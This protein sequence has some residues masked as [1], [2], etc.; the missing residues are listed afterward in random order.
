MTK[1]YKFIDLFSGCG[2]FSCGLEMAGFE[3]VLGVDFDKDA[4]ASFAKNHPHAQT[5]CG[6]IKNLTNDYLKK[7]LGNTKIDMIVGGPPCQ[8]F[9]TVGKGEASDPRNK[10][11]LEFVRIVKFLKPKILVMENVTGLLASKNQNTLNSIIKLFSEMGYALDAR[12]L[13]AEEYGVPEKRRRTFIIG[14]KNCGAPEFPQILCGPRGVNKLK[15]VADALKNLN[16]QIANHDI[17]SAQI[18]NK[19]DYERLKCIP[20]GKGIRYK[21][22]NDKYLPKRL[23]FKINWKKLREGRFRQ[24]KYQRL[25]PKK[26]SFTILTSRT[27]YYHPTENRYLTAREAARIQSFPDQFV[28]YGSVTSQFRQIGNAVPPMLAKEIGMTLKRILKS[29]RT[30]KNQTINLDF[31]KRAFHY[32]TNVAA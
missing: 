19:L 8:G 17:G 25:D 10:L 18:K 14:T 9:S 2:G 5:Y 12:V 7:T 15:T 28:F 13:S 29:K 1:K 31:K 4:A 11:F 16:T 27:M 6:D 23:S 20:T 22:D 24:T 3:C 32:H 21:S 26:P 30:Q